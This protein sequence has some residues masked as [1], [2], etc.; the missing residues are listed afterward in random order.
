[1]FATIDF[2]GEKKD[3]GLLAIPN[4]VSL[5][6]KRT[7]TGFKISAQVTEWKPLTF[8]DYVTSISYL[9]IRMLHLKSKPQIWLCMREN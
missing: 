3:T 6:G 8:H 2:F 5:G 7:S 9:I 4:N 1:M